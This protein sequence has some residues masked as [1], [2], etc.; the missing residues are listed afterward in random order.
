MNHSVFDL[1]C[2]GGASVDL[3]L[4]VPHMPEAADKLVT[5]LVGRFPGGLIANTAC[6]AAQLGLHT[7]W[8]GFIGS[9]DGGQL[10]LNDFAHFGVDAS[11][12]VQ[13]EGKPSDFC[14][15]LLQP[16]GERT[17][18]VVNSLPGL[19]PLDNTLRSSIANARVLYT[20]PYSLD[21]FAELSILCHD[22]GTKL[23]VD[24]ESSSPQQGQALEL[25]L[26]ACDIA[27]FSQGGL[28][29]AART[30]EPLEGAKSLLDLGLELVVV[31][32]GAHGAFAVTQDEYAFL[33]AFSVPAVDTTGAGDCF[34]A[35]Y[36]FG[37]Q[38][39]WNI[40]RCLYFAHAAAAL[41]I[42]HMG[43]RGGLPTREQVDEFLAAQ[44]QGQM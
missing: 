30:D 41:S 17:I 18:L 10:L 21:W 7:S 28:K 38:Q 12:A 44:P 29:L 25:I 36:L 40:T 6:A 9:D 14:V 37:Y 15:I 34:H 5:P 13:V 32:L 39:G 3:V 42:Q 26:R 4:N 35:A 27:F 43:A 8:T 24:I 2:L 33:P 11:T 22:Y 31:T 1:L 23:A 20:L 16:S 19:P